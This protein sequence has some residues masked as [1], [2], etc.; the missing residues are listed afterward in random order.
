MSFLIAL[1]CL[2][3]ACENS[4]SGYQNIDH[5]DLARDL[6]EN[7]TTLKLKLELT[8][9][10]SHGWGHA[11]SGN[12]K[13]AVVGDLEDLI[14]S[15]HLSISDF[16]KKF[17]YLLSNESENQVVAEF[18]LIENDKPY[19]NGVNAFMDEKGRTWEIVN[20]SAVEKK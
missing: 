10:L 3:C 6:E 19:I 16:E 2:L 8:Y 18:A 11:Y 4:A 1:L 5:T 13:E 15:L 17:S 7:Q 14:I 12:V 9:S 20:I